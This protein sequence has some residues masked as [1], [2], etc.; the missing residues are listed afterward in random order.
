M[1]RIHRT[2]NN[3]SITLINLHTFLTASVGIRSLSHPIRV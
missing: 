3:K 2:L 1:N